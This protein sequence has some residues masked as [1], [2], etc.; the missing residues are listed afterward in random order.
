MEDEPIY[1]DFNATTPVAE[2]VLDAVRAA[3][4]DAWGNPSSAHRYGTRARE[5]VEEARDRVASLL[6]A[7]P[8]EIVFTS[9]GTESDNAAVIGVAE[10]LERRGRHLV[11][12]AIEH[13]AVE[14]AARYLEGRGWSVSRVR[15][16]SDGRVAPA[17]IE[18]ALRPETVLVSLMH[19]NNETGV[20]QPVRE[21][22]AVA[23]ARG[24]PVHT[25]AAQSVGKIPVRTDDLG[26]DL[27]TV[28]GH[29]LYAPKGIG[30]LYLRRGTPF[31][32]FLRG[33]GH[34][35]GRR[36]G[37][38]NIPGIVGL[39]AACALASREIGERAAR[40]ATTRDRLQAALRAR[41]PSLVVHGA[42]ADRLPNTLS[43]AI[44]GV[45][46]N[47]LLAGLEGVAASAGAACHSGGTEPSR[48]LLAMGVDPDVARCTLRLTTG[49]TTTLEQVD[50]AAERIASAAAS[51]G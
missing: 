15:V 16:D 51:I 11:I 34:E 24:I 35:A 41:F 37:T 25:D 40:L 45:D 12:S 46:A 8:D 21:A 26:V 20:V 43:A 27:L 50:L 33:A 23:R 49:R 14:E 36:A 9:G 13:P 47:T 42:H 3:L 5:A 18:A 2:E 30:A 17:E 10:A 29:K 6:G 28:A 48:V 39:G 38:E 31:A 44:P 22:A 32:G 1:L 19:A 4:R 7:R